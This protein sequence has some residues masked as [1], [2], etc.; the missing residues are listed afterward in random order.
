MTRHP[1]D[2]RGRATVDVHPGTPSAPESDGL[3]LHDA[4]R[5]LLDDFDLPACLEIVRDDAKQDETFTGLSSEHP[6]VLRF[7]DV[8]ETL[9]A[10]VETDDDTARNA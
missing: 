9:R 3:S 1:D 7:R 5:W 8:C 4:I 6:R 10:A 2:D